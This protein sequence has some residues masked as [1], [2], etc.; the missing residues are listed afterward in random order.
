MKLKHQF[1]AIAALFL[2][3][4]TLNNFAHN[5][6][7]MSPA[8]AD[9]EWTNVEV[10]VLPYQ[11]V[12]TYD[13]SQ[14][15][16]HFTFSQ[17]DYGSLT[18][19]YYHVS[20]TPYFNI[21]D[22]NFLSYIQISSDDVTYV[23]FSNLYDSTHQNYFWKNGRLQIGI[24]RNIDTIMEDGKTPY[25]K[26]LEGCEFP[27]YEYC[28][29]G[30]TKKKFVQQT[31]TISKF[32]SFAD[33]STY[34]VSSYEEVAQKR[35]VNYTGIAPGWNNA[36]SSTGY[37]SIILSFGTHN[38][39]FLADD[40]QPNSTNR[41]T[42]GYD[43][44]N[45][46]TINGLPIY[47]IH[48]KFS[49]T[50]VGY[51]HGFAYF[52]VIYPV[53]VL[54]I[55]PTYLVPTLHIEPGAE[56]IDVALPEVTLKFIGG[57]WIASN[58]DEYRISEPLNLDEY[59]D[60]DMSLPFQFDETAHAFFGSLPE[61]GCKLA[62]N[63]N[64]GNIDPTNSSYA[65]NID[66]IYKTLISIAPTTGN[67][68]LYNKDSGLEL[69][70]SLS[71]FVFTPNTDYTFELEIVCGTTTTLKLAI[72]HLVV[73][74]YTFNN[75]KSG[76]CD[77]WMIDTSHQ[78]TVDYYK[79]VKQYQPIINYGGT[80]SYDFMEGDPVYNFAGVVNAFDLYDDSISAA[81]LVYEYEEGAVTEGKYN[82]GTWT[83]TIS[84]TVE[85]YPTATKVITINVHGTTSMAKISY[86]DG[87]VFEVPIG[88][89]LVPP[90][91][92]DTY[93]E[94]EY[95]Y[96]FDGW[97]FAGAKWDFENDIVQGDMHLVSRFVPT[98]PHYIVTAIFEG[99]PKNSTT[100]SLTKGSSLPF[101]VFEMEGATF[102]VFYN[103]T[104]IT[105]LV[106]QGDMTIVVRYTIVFTYVPAKDA[107]CTENGNVGYWYS[108][109]YA[110]YYFADS[111]GRELIP[112]VIIPK[113]NHDIIHLDYMDSSCHELGHVDCYYCNNCQKH[114]TDQI[115]ENELIDWAI[116]KKPHV[117]THHD[118]VE[119]TCENEGTLE[120][121]TCANEPG[122]YY[123]DEECTFELET[124]VIAALGHDYRNPTYTWREVEGGYECVASISCTHCHDV[125]TETKVATKVVVREATCSKEGQISY[126]V[127]FDNEKFSAQT[128]I[129]NTAKS[130]H[131]Y[132][133]VG[134]LEPTKNMNGVKEHYE[135][136]ECHK[137][138][139]KD[140]ETYKEVEFA[141]L[142][143]KSKSS[144]CQSS[145]ATPSLIVLVSA[146]ALS[147]LLMLRKKE[148]R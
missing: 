143:F 95:D 44:G 127:R 34:G 88:S 47:K 35:Q 140:G 51:D 69:V 125:F 92:P 100:Y 33:G 17:N 133:H 123:G 55:T 108:A 62:F 50:H 12:F 45:K 28:A 16:F 19:D 90:P 115:G 84:L 105:S 131:T 141:D 24:R 107:T 26:I 91:N 20:A 36:T 71:G 49:R 83:L 53:E 128:K 30:G 52:W 15:Y 27:S 120:H 101:E 106:V 8:K 113:Y 77:L 117:L 79:E 142:L 132:V 29:N 97:Y 96:V 139:L 1:I 124:I 144:G 102:E 147:A 145:V 23:D 76:S 9:G 146:G 22:Y 18:S 67:I 136:S 13:A 126:S 122:V 103:D 43:I 21:S 86:D 109:I 10:K 25:V 78:F 58:A 11:C 116:A 57:S 119:A 134:Q 41:A 114:F 60:G 39:D 4:F 93:R 46:L 82:A 129:I 110:G 48:D 138:F 118:G 40:H 98:N 3:A 75:D 148:E 73:L 63:M 32:V 121:W 72:N 42:S 61:D 130:P 59:L 65:L 56:F 74:N 54:S 6:A 37:R 14:A 7:D 104:K 99:L 94:G 89:K 68:N 111:E 38:V 87:D 5:S 85:G 80:T 31:T 137:Y 64:S 66:G 70:Q 81:N 112:N 135:C 2:T